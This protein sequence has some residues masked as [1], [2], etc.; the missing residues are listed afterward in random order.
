MIPSC[1]L[2]AVTS[3]VVAVA[4]AAAPVAADWSTGVDLY[5]QGRFAEAAEHFQAVVRSNPNWPGGYLMLGRCQLALE[6]HDEAVENLRTAVDLDPDDPTNTATLARA[7]MT[8]DRHDEARE[9]LDGLDADGLS[10]DWKA[11]VVRMQAACLIKEDRAVDAVALLEA[12]LADDPDRAALHRAIADAHRAVGDRTAV[13]DDLAR[14]FSLDPAD[15]AS[16]R[17]AVLAALSLAADAGDDDLETAYFGRAVEIADELATAS[18]D[19]EHTLLAGEA[20]FAAG[21]FDAAAGWFAAA[22]KSRPQEPVA[23]F[24]LGRALA[25]L[26]HDEE[27]VVHL[28]AALGAAPEAELAA[29]IHGQLGRLLACRLELPEAARH[30]RAAG[31]HDR[32]DQIDTVA[33]G[34]H[35][36]LKRLA[37]LRN[38]SAEFARMEAELDE[39]GDAKGVAAL[40]ERR[41]LMNRE[42]AGIEGN[43]SEVRAALCR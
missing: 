29:Q 26:D 39:L 25:V 10:P 17:A 1:R 34:L 18:P 41:E 5:H 15:H 33:A 28:R 3:V 13:L 35:E 16:G 21:R 22:V 36:A 23:R 31:D 19:Y 43:L 11:E 30:Y 40:A 24:E 4:L 7:L 20:A 12:C 37:T 38:N 2:L 27:A 42:I 14:A 32:A 8:A 9:L 6:N